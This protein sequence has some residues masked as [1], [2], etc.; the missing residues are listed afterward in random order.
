VMVDYGLSGL[1]LIKQ[2]Q[3]EAM[4]LDIE[5]REKM[6]LVEKCA[7]IEFRMVEGADEFVQLEALLSSFAIAGMEKSRK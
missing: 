7:E 4:K 5:P 1:D 3:G 6:A 2:I